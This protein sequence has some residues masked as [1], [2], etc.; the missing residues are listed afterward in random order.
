MS[1]NDAPQQYLKLIIIKNG[2][3]NAMQGNGPQAK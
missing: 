3:V 2:L 1:R